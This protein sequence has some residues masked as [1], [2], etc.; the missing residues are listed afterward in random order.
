LAAEGAFFDLAGSAGTPDRP[1]SEEPQPAQDARPRKHTSARNLDDETTRSI[2]GSFSWNYQ[3]AL[4]R[5]PAAY[6]VLPALSNAAN[7]FLGGIATN[8]FLMDE[9]AVYGTADIALE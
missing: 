4:L 1:A 7:S 6:T 5:T 8:L 3:A 2:V 9:T